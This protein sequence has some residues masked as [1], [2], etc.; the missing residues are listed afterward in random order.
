MG[1]HVAPNVP[2]ILKTLNSD[3]FYYLQMQKT[4]G[5]KLKR[6]LYKK[7]RKVIEHKKRKLFVKEGGMAHDYG[8]TDT[9]TQK[10]KCG[11]TEH[12]RTSHRSCPLNS[13]FIGKDDDKVAPESNAV[14]AYDDL[15]P[16]FIM[17]VVF[18]KLVIWKMCAFNLV[19]VLIIHAT[20]GNVLKM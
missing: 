20:K 8:I 1:L 2:S 9:L 14:D 17:K 18:L 6:K 4:D 19:P 10:C 11:S 3:R 16:T 5:A 15:I 7:Q 13:N 12:K